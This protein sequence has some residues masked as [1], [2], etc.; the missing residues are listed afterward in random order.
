MVRES[1]ALLAGAALGFC[2]YEL[3][4][5]VPAGEPEGIAP[6][7]TA[8]SALG[9][10]PCPTGSPSQL[11]ER[12]VAAQQQLAHAR[13][14]FEAIWGRPIPPPE[15]WTAEAETRGFLEMARALPLRHLEV[16]CDVY[17]C[18]AT[19]LV[20]EDP[21]TT[22]SELK[23]GY[24]L[25]SVNALDGSDGSS[26]TWL[27]QA[28]LLPPGALSE[29]DAEGLRW[30]EEVTARAVSVRAFREMELSSSPD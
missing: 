13:A 2:A 1:L 15:G 24:Q 3:W 23:A 28:V 20:Q 8:P 29:L 12:A 30:V 16:D 18:V 7:L 22:R 25:V 5:E 14:A 4:V 19:A 6:A 26:D 21:A 9:S 11:E 10:R 17:P 27:L